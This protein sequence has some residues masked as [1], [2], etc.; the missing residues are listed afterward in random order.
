MRGQQRAVGCGDS[1]LRTR[2][3]GSPARSAAVSDADC[4]DI[5]LDWTRSEQVE[6]IVETIDPSTISTRSHGLYASSPEIDLYL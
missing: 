2:A 1:H 6:D 4:V 5:L 3:R